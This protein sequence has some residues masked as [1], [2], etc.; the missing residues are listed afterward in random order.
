MT[1]L[2]LATLVA[3]L[4]CVPWW[5]FEN[6]KQRHLSEFPDLEKLMGTVFPDD[7]AAIRAK[8]SL[9]RAEHLRYLKTQHKALKA[10][11]KRR[12]GFIE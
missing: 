2:G 1:E 10:E 9:S 3:F 4:I 11:I 7:L 12:S 8:G 6:Y 5:F